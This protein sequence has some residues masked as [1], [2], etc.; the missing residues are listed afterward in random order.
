MSRT[1]QALEA[2]KACLQ[3]NG[4]SGIEIH[5]CNTILHIIIYII[6]MYITYIITIIII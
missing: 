5:F 4:L 1:F 6:I 2:W 3:I